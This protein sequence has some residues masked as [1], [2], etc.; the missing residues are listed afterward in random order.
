MKLFTAPFKVLLWLSLLIS[1][2]F[3]LF[4]WLTAYFILRNTVQEGYVIPGIPTAALLVFPLIFFF[5]SRKVWYRRRILLSPFPASWSVILNR[6][7]RFYKTLGEEEKRSFEKRIQVFI[8][9]KRITGI[10]TEIDDKTRVLIGASAIIPVFMFPQ[11]EYDGLGEILVYPQDFTDDYEF[12]EKGDLQGMY[13]PEGNTMIISKPS[14]YRGFMNN[15]DG[16][17][18][19]IHEFMHRIDGADG[20]IDGIPSLLMEE[21][22]QVEWKKVMDIEIERIERGRSDIDPYAATD[23]AEFFAVAGEYFFERPA[24]LERKHPELYRILKRIFRLDA[25]ML[26][27]RALKS[28][29][30]APFKRGRHTFMK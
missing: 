20:I 12:R 11:W 5:L 13:H 8:S 1:L 16:T 2:L 26:A 3:T 9:E 10:E 21:S 14:L 19:G 18:V 6:D 24:E 17:N 29:I 4:A 28:M 30:S 23:E 15:N 22:L 25:G 7:V 27:R